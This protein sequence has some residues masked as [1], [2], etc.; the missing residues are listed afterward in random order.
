MKRADD[1]TGQAKQAD[2][3]DALVRSRSSVLD[4]FHVEDVIA[5]LSLGSHHGLPLVQPRD[6]VVMSLTLGIA[7]SI[8]ARGI[9][10]DRLGAIFHERHDGVQLAVRGSPSDG[11]RATPKWLLRVRVARRAREV[12]A[13]QARQGVNGVGAAERREAVERAHDEAGQA[14]NGDGANV[15]VAPRAPVLV[16]VLVVESLLLQRF[17]HRLLPGGLGP[18]LHGCA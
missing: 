1:E 7:P 17:V 14:T 11:L 15:L 12:L 9:L 8:E 4:C 6:D 3:R 18:S 13:R 5:H 2:N 16:P 10:G